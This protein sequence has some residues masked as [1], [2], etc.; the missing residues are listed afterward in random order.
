MMKVIRQ[1]IWILGFLAVIYGCKVEQPVVTTEETPA[2]YENIDTLPEIVVP[3]PEPVIYH[4]SRTRFFDLLHTRLEISLDWE[5]QRADGE[6]LLHLKPYFYPQ[7]KLL[8]DAKNFDI[9]HVRLVRGMERED[10][11]WEYDNMQ[12]LIFLDTVYTRKNDLFIE[13]GYTAKPTER[14]IGGSLAIESDQGLYFINPDGSDPGKPTQ[15]WTQG[16]TEANS[17]WFPTI[18]S[19]NERMTQ[20]IFLTVDEKYVTLSNGELVYSKFNADSTRTDYWK[21]DQPHAPYLAMI[22]VGEFAIIEDSWKDIPLYYYIE[23]EYAE[24][25]RDIFGATPEMMTFFSE[26]IGMKYPWNKY[27]QIIVRDYVSGAMENTTASLFYDNMLV[28]RRELIDEN[29]EGI[30]AHELF[31]QWFG[32]LVTLESWANL[33][34]NE[35]FAN[36]SEYLWNEYKY[37]KFEAGLHDLEETMQY[38][39]EAEIE[40]KDLIRFNYEDK[41]DMFDSHSYAKG[42]RV[43]HMLR[44]YVGDEAFFTSLKLYLKRYQY[45][46]VEIHQL[47]LIFEEVTGED[48]NWFFNQWFLASGHPVLEIRD[49]FADSVLT[50]TVRQMQDL[51]TTPVYRLPVKV[52]VWMKNRKLQYEI[53]VDQ[54]DQQFTFNLDEEPQLVVFDSDHQLLAEIDHSRSI[55]EYFYLYNL[56]D[57]FYPRYE[58]LDT[59]LKDI[60]DSLN[61][62]VMQDALQDEFWFFRQMAVNALE[63]FDQPEKQVIE[64]QLKELAVKDEKS[65]VRADALNTLYSMFGEKYSELYRN[66]LYDSS[67]LVAGTAIY[68]YSATSP[69]EMSKV[70]SQFDRYDNINIVIPLASFYIDQGGHQKYDW[71][72]D[73]IKTAKSETLWYLLQYFG[74]YIMDAP[75]LVQRRGIALLELYARSH[76]KNYVR[77]SAYQSLGLLTDLS[78]VPELREDIRK[79]EEDKYLQQLYG[80]L[81]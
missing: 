20:E 27:A 45:Q 74:E 12:L 41:E 78:G 52:D 11:D 75:E 60:S 33:T 2:I 48:L 28:D 38:L 61:F 44:N 63:G 71:F 14:E 3:E 35:G 6:A 66:A 15:V 68:I 79:K 72:A 50:L 5:R 8:L 16:E 56:T 53:V 9:H 65:Q 29:F 80:S 81:P 18:D 25:A 40:K 10:L 76:T 73:K 64:E 26:L 1:S 47:R 55:Q 49:T 17:F 77:L 4:A 24:Y 67:Y 62:V 19:P 42:G 43:L 34:L 37:G 7:D 32:D 21:L 30:I 69:Q 22:A 36:Y 51:S 31:H 13:V 23:P 57:E 59:L 46:T 54:P 58:A 70:A 39:Q